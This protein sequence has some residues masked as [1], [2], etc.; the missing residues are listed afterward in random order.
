[1]GTKIEYAINILGTSENSSSLTVHRVDDWD[2]FQKSGLKEKYKKARTEDKIR[3]SMDR[4]LD[5]HNIDTIKKTMQMHEDTFKHQIR[6]LHRLYSVQKMLMD[7]LKKEMKRN[8][9]RGPVTSSADHIN[10]SQ[11]INWQHS[12]TQASSGYNFHLQR[13]RDDPI[14]REGSGSCS[15]DTLRMSR[16][17]DLERPAEED[18]ST[19]VSTIDQEQAGPSS[20]MAFKS[21]NM[22]IAG[23]DEDSEVELTLS[24]GSSKNKKRSKSYQPQLG[25]AEL[26]HKET[27]LDSPASFK[28]D[29]GGD[30]SDP[31]TP[32]S[33]SSATFDQER[34]QPHW[35]FHGLKLK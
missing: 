21:R 2:Y 11:L 14:S 19:G 15:G 23:C 30:C 7:E 29:R 5:K 28:S 3:N 8:I 35:L 4:M 32:M 9:F 27:D 6:E 17:F 24:I 16:G 18:M 12:T 22:S 10:H 20:H 25:C 33:S 1:M 13:L 31:T 26:I 34:K